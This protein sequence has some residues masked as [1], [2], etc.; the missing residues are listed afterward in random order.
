[1]KKLGKI[2]FVLIL[3]S[4]ILAPLAAEKTKTITWK[5]QLTDPNIVVYRYQLDG[6]REDG[7]TTVAG[8]VDSF[9]QSGLDPYVD[10][11]LAIQ[12]SYDGRNWS[13]SSYS[14]A[15]AET[16][17]EGYVAPSGTY[18]PSVDA[19]TL[20]K[21]NTTTA[22]P[23]GTIVPPTSTPST[24][25]TSTPTSTTLTPS[26]NVSDKPVE[27]KKVPNARFG[28]GLT[29]NVGAEMELRKD[30][31]TGETSMLFYPRVGANMDFMNI[32]HFGNVFGIGLR[33]NG[34]MNLRPNTADWSFVT[35][36]KDVFAFSNYNMDFM[37]G[38]DLLMYFNGKV[39][40][41]YLG[42]G[43]GYAFSFTQPNPLYT[44]LKYNDDNTFGSGIAIQAAT[45]LQFKIKHFLLTLDIDGR[46]FVT[47]NKEFTVAA[48]LGM[49]VK[50]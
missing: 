35:E 39:V 44:N 30:D 8:N 45:G 1:M 27:I 13:K 11:V 48:T 10:H 41:F 12:A 33:I 5:W 50:F 29:A 22:S 40:N 6:E 21:E 23:Q 26:E 36:F 46:W 42:A 34:I 24:S 18:S 19:S 28:F 37:A 4:L 47:T 32:V 14:V 9:S 16:A 20:P 31:T 49:G 17:P 7:W 3:F 25:T 43:A 15:K 2:L 38:G